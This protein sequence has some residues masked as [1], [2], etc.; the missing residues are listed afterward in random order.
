MG[1]PGHRLP[2]SDTQ[3]TAS[4]RDVWRVVKQKESAGEGDDHGVGVYSDQ[5]GTD[6]HYGL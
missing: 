3:W 6:D 1:V 5:A 2:F 4:I